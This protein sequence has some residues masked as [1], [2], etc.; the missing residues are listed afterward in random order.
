MNEWQF[1]LVMAIA[2]PTKLH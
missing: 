1:G 2:T